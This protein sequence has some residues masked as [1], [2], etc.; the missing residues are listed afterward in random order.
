V[1]TARNI[2]SWY[3]DEPDCQ[4]DVRSVDVDG[5]SVLQW[6]DHWTIRISRKFTTLRTFRPETREEKTS[7]T[8]KT[9]AGYT[10]TWY[11][12]GRKFFCTQNSA[13]ITD[14]ATG[15]GT[16]YQTWEHYTDWEDIPATMIGVTGD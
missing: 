16:E 2:D 13:P 9:S 8:V 10:I 7:F 6:R 12:T 1:I 11:R 15:E 5:T 4:V 14:S 3:M